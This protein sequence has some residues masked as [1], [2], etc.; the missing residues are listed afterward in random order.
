MRWSH[1][2]GFM[3]RLMA[4]VFALVVVGPVAIGIFAFE[5]VERMLVPELGKSAAVIGRAVAGQLAAAIDLGIPFG[6]LR[7]V[8]D[9]LS[10]ILKDNRSI[11]YIAVGDERGKVL[12]HLGEKG[13]AEAELTRLT[14]DMLTRGGGSAIARNSQ[15][16]TE[17]LPSHYNTVLPILA[18]R[19]AVGAVHVG[20]DRNLFVQELRGV[21]YK[22]L[23]V[24]AVAALI[25]FEIMLLVVTL[26][27]G[28]PT[29]SIARVLARCKG[30]DFSTLI[31]SAIGGGMAGLIGAINLVIHHVNVSFHRLSR[32]VDAAK[33]A[34]FD[35]TVIGKIEDVREEVLARLMPGP[36]RGA[37]TVATYSL[38]ALRTP[39]FLVA[40]AEELL[41]PFLPVHATS[42]STGLLAVG[43]RLAAAL[44]IA[45]FVALA[46]L[47][48]LLASRLAQRVGART[49]FAIGAL[50]AALGLALAGTSTTLDHFLLKRALAGIGY[51]LVIGVWFD[52]MGAI[53]EPERRVSEGLLVAGGIA[54]AFVCGPALGGL[55]YDSLGAQP[56]FFIAAAIAAIAALVGLAALPRTSP[57]IREPEWAPR[58]ADLA[59][60]LTNSRALGVLVLGALPLRLA[61][62]G[63]LFY[64]VPLRLAAFKTDPTLGGLIIAGFGLAVIVSLALARRVIARAIAPPAAIGA[65]AAGLALILVLFVDAAVAV[66]AAIVVLGL[67]YAVSLAALRVAADRAADPV[68]PDIDR[69][70]FAWAVA[71]LAELG[72]ACGP[73]LAAVLVARFG[74]TDTMAVLGIGLL[75]AAALTL[76]TRGRAAAGAAARQA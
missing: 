25:G 55:L 71:L 18:A 42:L 50:A 47:A 74:L 1:I 49:L 13:V 69:R 15:A 38:V 3:A 62:T 44:P 29:G 31:A 65:G 60:V 23:V 48:A 12:H 64:L 24:I 5:A 66:P 10:A 14:L 63:V 56:V 61:L 20:V 35:K 26:N 72:G 33:A 34:Q 52:R 19:G 46:A 17:A 2:R 73:L 75:I 58:A 70:R 22:I 53:A 4:V 32:A 54:L 41:R 9:Y 59:A 36:V 37:A 30:G 7:G 28:L 67:A 76:L 6:Q 16:M 8:D 27:I 11:H 45:V 21:G 43:D 57:P 40:L 51:G 68:A 39:L